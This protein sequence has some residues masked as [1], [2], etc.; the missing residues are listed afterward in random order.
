MGTQ[1]IFLDA[2]PSQQFSTV[3]DG[4]RVVFVFKYNTK[5]E[6][7][8]FDMSVNDE[9]VLQ[10]RTLVGDTDV[11]SGISTLSRQ[12]G[13]LVAL[14]IDDKGRPPT[15]ENIASGNVRVFMVSP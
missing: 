10:G 11:L 7:F 4:V 1:R 8:Y 3:V 14:D 12:F 2:N 5:I 6:R 13:A 9:F 15:L